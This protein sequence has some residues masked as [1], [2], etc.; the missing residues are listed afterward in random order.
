[1][2]PPREGAVKTRLAAQLGPQA[3][4]ALARAFFEDT[5]AR[6]EVPWAAR[7][8]ASTEDCREALGLPDAEL[9]LQGGGDLG[10][11]MHRI[12]ERALTRFPWAIAVGADCPHLPATALEAGR[13]ALSG[14][15]DAVLGPARDG[16]YYLLGLKRLP[17]G[18]L[19][20]LPW[21]SPETFAAT[22][23]RLLERDLKTV[24]LE[25]SFDIDTKEDVEALARLLEAQP[26][27]APHSAHALELLRAR[28]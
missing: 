5:W 3:A 4:V 2:K 18:L 27:L 12:F 1:M 19:D 7:V 16:G 22:Q 21:S 17:T 6:V 14:D 23:K 13:A 9:W 11:R 25:P 26:A 10:A 24:V 28:T 8:L 15:A 20:G